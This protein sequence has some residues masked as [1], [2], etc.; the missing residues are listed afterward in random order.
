VR[1]VLFCRAYL[2]SVL[3]PGIAQVEKEGKVTR[4]HLTHD[5]FTRTPDNKFKYR[6]MVPCYLPL[7][8]PSESVVRCRAPPRTSSHARVVNSHIDL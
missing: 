7:A 5:R 4:V 2:R 8:A 1:S 3:V 6:N